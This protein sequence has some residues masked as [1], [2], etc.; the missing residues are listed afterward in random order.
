MSKSD[1]N[2]DPMEYLNKVRAQMETL[3]LNE[4]ANEEALIAAANAKN[5]MDRIENMLSSREDD[6]DE[7]IAKNRPP[8]GLTAEE[9]QDWWTARIAFLSK[10]VSETYDDHYSS[11]NN[12]IGSKATVIADSKSDYDE[13]EQKKSYSSSK[14][15]AKA[16]RK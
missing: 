11:S 15:T 13:D 14:A 10:P 5:S 12:L 2:D 3:K 4:I 1:D 6:D 16:S 7:R 8:P 9:E